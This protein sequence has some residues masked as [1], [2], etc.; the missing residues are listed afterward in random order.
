MPLAIYF[1]CLISSIWCWEDS[2]FHSL[3]IVQMFTLIVYHYIIIITHFMME[4]LS[5]IHFEFYW[6]SECKLNCDFILHWKWVYYVKQCMHYWE[7]WS[8]NHAIIIYFFISKKEQL[9]NAKFLL[10]LKIYCSI[11]A[12]D[13]SAWD[14]TYLFASNVNGYMEDDEK[15]RRNNR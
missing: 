3:K 15:K 14:F 11:Q 10:E 6:L 9:L 5:K 4:Y 13:S 2:V 7:E 8:E 12:K 1:F